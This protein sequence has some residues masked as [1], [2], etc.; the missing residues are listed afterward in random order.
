[1]LIPGV[2]MHRNYQRNTIF[3]NIFIAIIFLKLQA[4]LELNNI[5]LATILMHPKLSKVSQ[6]IYIAICKNLELFCINEQHDI[7]EHEDFDR[8]AI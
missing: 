3:A 7:E 8:H 1:M 5:S 6:E 4:P 2:I